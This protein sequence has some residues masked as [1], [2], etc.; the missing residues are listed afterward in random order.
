MEE[1]EVVV[2]GVLGVEEVFIGMFPAVW[3]VGRVLVLGRAFGGL[4]RICFSA[5]DC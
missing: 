1:Q 3:V 4:Y 5:P 2:R